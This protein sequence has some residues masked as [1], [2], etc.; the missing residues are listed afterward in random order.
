MI[1]C[2]RSTRSVRKNASSTYPLPNSTDPILRNT[3]NSGHSRDGDRCRRRLT[4]P[5][6]SAEQ[7]GS[8]IT[9][10]RSGS[11]RFDR[12]AESNAAASR[13]H[14]RG[15]ASSLTPIAVAAM[16]NTPM[17]ARDAERTAVRA[18]RHNACDDD[19]DDDRLH[20]GEGLHHAR[21][22]AESNV[23]PSARQRTIAAAG[24]MNAA[25]ATIR[26]GQPARACPMWIAS[27]VELGPGMRLVAPT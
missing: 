3:A 12:F 7:R 23:A 17:S 9:T 22:R 8:P 16:A 15:R 6:L 21:Q 14:R 27:S 5:P 11:A 13:H 20:A 4:M 1:Q 25:P 26:P 24:R 18:S 19:R 10:D 2:S